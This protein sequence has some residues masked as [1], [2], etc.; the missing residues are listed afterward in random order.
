M[1]GKYEVTMT[2]KFQAAAFC[3][4]S[5]TILY[6]HRRKYGWKDALIGIAVFALWPIVS[7]YLLL[8]A[9]WCNDSSEEKEEDVEWWQGL[10]FFEAYGESLP[11]V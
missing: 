10:N 3:S 7:P 2:V 5:L 9:T 6:N 1:Y 11:Q 8:K 4:F